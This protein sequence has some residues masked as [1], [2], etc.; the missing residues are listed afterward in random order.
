[1][2]SKNIILVDKRIQSYETIISAVNNDTCIYITIDYYTE[3]IEDIKSKILNKLSF[4]TLDPTT[5]RCIGLIQHNYNLPFYSLVQPQPSSENNQSGSIVFG[6]DIKDSLL[7]SWSELREFIVWC[8][9]APEVNAQYFDMMACALYSDTNWKYII[10]ALTA[11]TGVTVRASTDNTGAASLGGNWFLESHTGV[12]L[13]SVYFTDAI[14]EFPG[15]LL[16]SDYLRYYGKG[17]QYKGIAAGSVVT[18]GYSTTGGDSSSASSSISSDVIS[19]YCNFGTFLALKTNGSLVMWG[20]TAGQITFS[21]VSS[22]LQSGVVDVQFSNGAFAALKSNGSVITWGDTNNG[23]SS[24]SV[25]SSLQSG[26]VALYSNKTSYAAL[27][28]DG[29]VISWWGNGTS[30]SITSVVA[31]YCTE[32]AF[33]ALK[34]DGSVVTWGDSGRGGNSSTVSSSLSS[35]VVTIYSNTEAFAALKNNGSVVTWG[36]SGCGG[37]SS[38]VSSALQSGVVRIYSTSR[39]FAALKSNGSVITWGDSLYG[40]NSVAW[41]NS[42]YGPDPS[43]SLQ[44]NVV[45]VYSNAHAFAALKNDGSIVTWGWV[46]GDS[47]SVAS[48]VSSGV[49]AVYGT[50]V[51]AFAALKSDGRVITWGQSNAGGDSSSVSSSLT[52]GVVSIYSTYYAFAALKNDGSVITWGDSANGANSSSVSSSLSSGV[53]GLR[54]NGGTFAALKTSVSTFDLSGSVYTDKDRYNILRNKEIRRRANLTT[55]NNNVFT[56]SQTS[57]LQ[58]LNPNIPSGKTLRIII[59]TYVA[60]SYTITS[61]ATIPNSSGNYVIACDECE[62]V[63]ISGTTYVNYGSYVYIFEANNTYTK[64][65]SATINGT[66]YTLY[67]GDGVNSSGIVFLEVVL[68]ASTFASSTFTVA[69]SKTFGDASFVITTRPTSNSAG[70]I[71]YSSSNT[72]VATIDASGNFITLVGAGDVS[73]NATQASTAQY[74]SSTKTSNTLTVARGTSTLASVSTVFEVASSKTFGDA[75]FVITTRPTSNNTTVPIVYSSSNT[76]VATIDTSGNFITLVGAGDVSFNATQAQT[77]QYNSATKTSNTLTVARGTS[78]L[79]SVATVFEVAS[80]KT[81]GDASFVITTRP[82]SNNTTVP[83]VY[84]SSNT[85]VAT[86]DASGNFITLVGTGDVSFNATQAQT[87]QYNSATKT[88]NTLTVARGTST[89]ASSTF[90]V[91]SSKTILDASFTITTRPTSNSSGAITYSS[92]NTSV[93]TIDASGNFITI[94]G[95]GTVTFT[96]TQA[97]TS[98]YVSATKT[99]NTLTVSKAMPTLAFVSPPTTKNVTDAA[100]TVTA[101]SASS[102]AVTYSSSNTSFATVNPSTGLVTLKGV[103]TVTITASQ[104]STATYEAPTNATCSI[105]IASAGTALQGQ[106][107]SSSTSYASV[108]LSGASLVGTTVSGVSFSGANLSNV[109]FSGAVITNTDF[110]NANISGATNLPTFSTVQKLQL[111]KN[112]NN[113]GISAVQVATTVSGSEINALLAT[114][115]STVAAA[116]F[117]VKPPSSLDGSANKVVTINSV[118]IS[119]GKSVYIP[120]N[121]NET[122]KINNVVYSFNGT[123]ILDTNGNPVTFAS[124]S[125]A[126]FKIYAGSVV[127]VNIE[128]ALNKINFL[129]DGLYTVLSDI[130]VFKNS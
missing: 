27:K 48:S 83:I 51:N 73:F 103:G 90:T 16:T 50:G 45:N 96:A 5:T 125:G 85:S 61:N 81:F 52:S 24:S 112:I 71:T 91:S 68:E 19:I 116:T 70:A 82:T 94:V 74:A 118:D 55:L 56:L 101:N 8:K 2:S 13:K 23:A 39:A 25:S 62:P 44:S 126:P 57:D 31:V 76:S 113:V 127:A 130:L 72:A 120:M 3:T 26:V 35:G 129:G 78:T 97:Q 4:L 41:A 12:N 1:M 67:G 59:P 29:S 28:S 43:P 123:N 128:D 84:S 86:I 89:L 77:N 18:W 53:I 117:T 33:A 46:S 114:P 66:A 37:D 75:S 22:N 92:N 36:T 9:T 42:N 63:T 47:S 20:N 98:Q 11:Q 87:N 32:L 109:N 58:F 49:V 100:F 79:A 107:V 110:T 115:N 30:S 14:E 102:G 122:V 6:V 17:Y 7:E 80:T 124:F 38:R 119:G 111:L 60:S 95:L 93:A 105:V 10:D 54:G 69:S 21:S 40:G 64:T 15:L 65:T 34:S 108:D 106:T 99:S 121:V 88:S 104:A